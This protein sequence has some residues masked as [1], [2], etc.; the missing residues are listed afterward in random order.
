VF[1]SGKHFHPRS[2]FVVKAGS[3]PIRIE[4]LRLSTQVISCFI[5]D[6]GVVKEY[7]PLSNTLAYYREASSFIKSVRVFDE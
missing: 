4:H 2:T 6:M 1:N 7:L 5:R 3:T